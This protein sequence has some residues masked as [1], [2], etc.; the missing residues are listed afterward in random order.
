MEYI[1]ISLI[2]WNSVTFLLYGL[3]KRKA[4]KSKRRISEKTLIL[5]AFLM[6]GLGCLFG[7]I[8]FRHKT[9]HLKFKILIPL[10]VLFNGV[11][12]IYLL[13]SISLITKH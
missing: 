11:L 5:I 2:V 9:K 1:Y 6:G 7:M 4:I 10:A 3:D 8:A 13:N 12:L